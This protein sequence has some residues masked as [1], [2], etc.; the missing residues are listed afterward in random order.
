MEARG[1]AIIINKKYGSKRVLA[2]DSISDIEL[3]EHTSY[4]GSAPK[5]E[6]ITINIMMKDGRLLSERYEPS[7]I[8]NAY[9]DYDILSEALEGAQTR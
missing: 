5:I 1:N 2:A 9:D 3:D 8:G 7:E 4:R 6:S